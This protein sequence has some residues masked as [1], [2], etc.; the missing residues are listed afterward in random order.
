MK[1]SN[2]RLVRAVI[3]LLLVSAVAYTL[4]L[5]ATK[6]QAVI[7]EGSMAPD[8]KLETLDGRTIKLSDYRGKGVFLNFWGTWCKPCEKEMPYMEKSYQQFKEKGVET[9]AVNI[10]ESDFIVNKFV[11]KYDLSF[12]FP[13]DRNRDLLEIYGVGPIPTTFLINPE[14]KVVKV[15]TG[16]MTQQDVHD[17]M[18]MI[19]PEQ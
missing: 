16:S 12:T 6:D 1:K 15:I 18:N 11:D 3:L 10:G 17:N 7:K 13:M 2:R 5:N 14:G 19:K 9:L 4:Y 8:F